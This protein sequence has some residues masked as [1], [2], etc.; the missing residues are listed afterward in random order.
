MKFPLKS[1]VVPELPFNY[2]EQ[3]DPEPIEIDSVETDSE[4][5][6]V[7]VGNPSPTIPDP[8]GLGRLPD[9][10]EVSRGETRRAAGFVGDGPVRSAPDVDDIEAIASVRL[11]DMGEKDGSMISN[12]DARNVL[13]GKR[14]WRV[15]PG[16]YTEIESLADGQDDHKHSPSRPSP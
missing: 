13:G 16:G 5:E 14:I 1:K 6:I 9:V 8:E 10:E 15:G 12:I 4:D 2:V 11:S 3:K 7:E